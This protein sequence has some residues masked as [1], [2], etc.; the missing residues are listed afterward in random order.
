[1]FRMSEPSDGNEEEEKQ[2]KCEMIGM[3][4]ER[5]G[6]LGNSERRRIVVSC[7]KAIG[8]V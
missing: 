5:R 4:K 8:S 1:M 2:G 6:K 3:M 7:K